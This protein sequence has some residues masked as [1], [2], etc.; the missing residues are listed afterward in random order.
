MIRDRLRPR[1][2]PLL[3]RWL[4]WLDPPAPAVVKVESTPNPAAKKFT[5]RPGIRVGTALDGLPMVASV[6]MAEDFVTVTK[7]GDA[8]WEEVEAA[9]SR[10]LDVSR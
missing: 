8:Q 9:V 10:A 7:R 5:L 1:I 4:D 6:F 2:R 3:L